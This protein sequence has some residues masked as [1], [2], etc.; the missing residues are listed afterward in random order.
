M[1]LRDS[2]TKRINEYGE[3]PPVWS[4]GSR[5]GWGKS[6][7]NNNRG[8]AVVE[9]LTYGTWEVDTGIVGELRNGNDI[10]YITVSAGSVEGTF[11]VRIENANKG[12]DR[13]YE[14]LS[15]KEEGIISD[16]NS[17]RITALK[18]SDG[19]PIF[20]E[21][22][23]IGNILTPR[24]VNTGLMFNPMIQLA[25]VIKKEKLSEYYQKKANDYIAAAI[26]ALEYHEVDWVDID[27]QRGYYSEFNKDKRPLPWNQMFEP[28]KVLIGIYNI[29]GE[30]Q[31][32]EKAEKMI[33]YF[34]ENLEYDKKNDLY[35]WKYLNWEGYTA[36][37]NVNYARIDMTFIYEAYRAG[38]GFTEEDMNRFINTYRKN[39]Y[40]S[41]DSIANGVNGK[42]NYDSEELFKLARVNFLSE[43]GYD[44]FFYEPV[45]W[46]EEI[47]NREEEDYEKLVSIARSVYQKRIID[48]E[49]V[50]I[51]DQKK[52]GKYRQ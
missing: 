3:S 30:V 37:E 16:D 25:E 28:G 29:T 4:S 19:L 17:V 12:F 40:R 42:G 31:F 24:P 50:D 10:T 46:V 2:E 33:N 34:K 18:A 43:W 27:D 38:I 48:P 26:D 22:D 9:V 41:D 36:T 23:Y 14:K 20:Q 44:Y 15:L 45:K 39:V 13:T 32:K 35:I 6:I 47:K 7:V 8:E 51:T 52:I 49:W 1:D 11:K 21:R 5:Y